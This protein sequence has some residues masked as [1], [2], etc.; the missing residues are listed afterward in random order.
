MYNCCVRGRAREGEGPSRRNM[1]LCGGAQLTTVLSL[2]SQQVKLHAACPLSA[3]PA[4]KSVL[5]TSGLEIP[6]KFPKHLCILATILLLLL[7]TRFPMPTGS[8][9]SLS[10]THVGCSP[11]FK[12]SLY[13]SVSSLTKSLPIF[14]GTAAT[15]CSPTCCKHQLA[16]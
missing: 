3:S 1:W 16:L 4:G 10:Q 5:F 6:P 15:A 7:L 14:P 12:L 13:S 2:C 8:Q 11:L 9:V